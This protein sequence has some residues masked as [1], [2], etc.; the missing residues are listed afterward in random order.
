MSRR[1]DELIVNVKDLKIAEQQ[2]EIALLSDRVAELE[3]KLTTQHVNTTTDVNDI[4]LDQ[5]VEHSDD[6]GE[7]DNELLNALS[8]STMGGN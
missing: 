8:G 6:H 7:D 5:D 1:L 4:E 3:R 2:R